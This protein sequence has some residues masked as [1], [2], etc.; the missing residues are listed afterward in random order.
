[1]PW[2]QEVCQIRLGVSA[3]MDGFFSKPYLIQETETFG[4]TITPGVEEM[5]YPIQET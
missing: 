1:M 3:F 2:L 4:I 5:P